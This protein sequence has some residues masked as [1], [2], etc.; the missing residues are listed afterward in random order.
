MS[1][2]EELSKLRAEVERH[3]KLYHQDDSPEISDAE[4]DALYSRLKELEGSIGLPD[5][6]SPTLSVG[7]KPKRGFEKHSHLKPM[8][9]LSNV[10]NIDEFKELLR[11]S[12][13]LGI[14]IITSSN[15]INCS[16]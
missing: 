2:E 4:Y 9:S 1:R 10:F 15:S 7:S 11:N 5:K 3:N 13:I 12:G 16:L 14:Q 6:T 8:L